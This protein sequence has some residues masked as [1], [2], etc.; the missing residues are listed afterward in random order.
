[1]T[2]II[3]QTDLPA[4]QLGKVFSLR[5]ILASAGGALGLLFAVPLF[6]LLSVP[7]AIALCALAMSAIGVAGL[8]R[9]GFTEPAVTLRTQETERIS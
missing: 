7:V 3:M 4:N 9:F 6:A 1:M 5:M 2:I 8:V